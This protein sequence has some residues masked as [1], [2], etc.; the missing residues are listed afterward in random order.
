MTAVTWELGRAA[1]VD[2]PTLLL[3]G[4]SALFLLRFKVNSAWLVAGGAAVGF[5]LKSVAP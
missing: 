5:V 4:T 2:A 3:A 1:L